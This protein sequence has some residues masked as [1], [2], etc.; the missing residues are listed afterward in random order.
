MF[1]DFH[2]YYS[3]FIKN[4][5]I[6]QIQYSYG[7]CASCH[8]TR[9]CHLLSK[10]LQEFCITNSSQL[11]VTCIST[12]TVHCCQSDWL[13]VLQTNKYTK[14]CG[15]SWRHISKQITNQNCLI[16]KCKRQRDRTLHFP[17]IQWFTVL[18]R[19][20]KGSTLEKPQWHSHSVWH[21]CITL[22]CNNKK[23]TRR[24]LS[25]LRLPNNN[26][27]YEWVKECLFYRL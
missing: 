26:V 13:Y 17:V 25:F 22:K 21:H 3:S 12:L 11:T 8:M 14:T 9:K 16:P 2:L 15:V 27:S 7:Y 5:G 1:Q 18:S 19:G 24:D 6:S 23:K 4:H 20:C 10:I